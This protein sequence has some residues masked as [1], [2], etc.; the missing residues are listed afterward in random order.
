V[1]LIPS[2]NG[3]VTWTVSSS[4]KV[5]SHGSVVVNRG[6]PIVFMAK[7]IGDTKY[8]WITIRVSGISIGLRA[9]VLN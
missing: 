7:T 3:R 6:K 5:L 9:W 2:R 4:H 1:K 8:S